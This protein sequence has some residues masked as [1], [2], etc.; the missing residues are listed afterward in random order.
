[1]YSNGKNA[2]KRGKDPNSFSCFFWLMHKDRGGSVLVRE[3]MRPQMLRSEL[4]IAVLDERLP[5]S[6]HM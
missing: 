6:D 5:F 1:M 3:D 4:Y 2:K